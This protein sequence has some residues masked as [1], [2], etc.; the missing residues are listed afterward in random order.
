MLISAMQNICYETP[1]K[2]HLILRFRTTVLDPRVGRF[3]QV[4]HTQKKR[5]CSQRTYNVSGKGGMIKK[6]TANMS[7]MSRGQEHTEETQSQK[8]SW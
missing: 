1:R 8:G 7:W 6:P 4:K 2:G 3:R 5:C